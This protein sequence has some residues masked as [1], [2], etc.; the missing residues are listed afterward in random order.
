MKDA[1]ADGISIARAPEA[2]I[3]RRPV[4]RRQVIVW[5]GTSLEHGDLFAIAEFGNTCTFVSQFDVPPG[6]PMF[7]GDVDPGDDVHASLQGAGV[8]IQNPWAQ[9]L[10]RTG[11]ASRLENDMGAGHGCT[12]GP[13]P[14]Q[15]ERGAK[16][17]WN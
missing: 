11:P 9:R 1:R 3:F 17:V 4:N 16:G 7:V 5:G 2:V 6:T 14:A 13:G 15:S 12:R 8:F 10:V